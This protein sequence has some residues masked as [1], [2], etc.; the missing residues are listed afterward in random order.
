MFSSSDPPFK[1]LAIFPPRSQGRPLERHA[2]GGRV[3]TPGGAVARLRGIAGWCAGGHLQGP[4]EGLVTWKKM[5]L[6]FF[7]MGLDGF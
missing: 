3:R 5:G 7:L 2:R 4:K 6:V 1:M